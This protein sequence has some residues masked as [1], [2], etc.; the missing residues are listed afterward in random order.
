MTD[1]LTCK[2]LLPTLVNISIL[3]AL[4]TLGNQL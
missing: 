4:L 2:Q 3:L 1:L